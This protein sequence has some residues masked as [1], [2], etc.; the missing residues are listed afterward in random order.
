MENSR[1]YSFEDLLIDDS[2]CIFFIDIDGTLVPDSQYFCSTKVLK[3]IKK[4][5]DKNEVYLVTNSKDQKRNSEI[6]KILNLS[7]TN[8]FYKKPNKKVIGNLI[9]S[10]K[11]FFVIGDKFLT[12]YLFAKNIGGNCI[13]VKRKL[14]GEERLKIILINLIDDIIYFFYKLFLKYFL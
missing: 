12:D 2:N 1:L 6:S 10:E 9:N 13:L 7:F 11:K 4:I 3:Q 14:S 8:V 5:T